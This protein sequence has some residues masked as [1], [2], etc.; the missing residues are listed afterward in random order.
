MGLLLFGMAALASWQ[1]R[2]SEQAAGQEAPKPKPEKKAKSK[3][4]DYD[5]SKYKAYRI[6]PEPG[7][8]R[9][10]ANGKPIL[11]QPK[12]SP[13]KKKPVNASEETDC[14]S[15]DACTAAEES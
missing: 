11:P 9:F 7:V 1:A 15:K 3:G 8:Y 2:A 13:A 5:K 14:Q 12:K 10:D 4:Y 6:D